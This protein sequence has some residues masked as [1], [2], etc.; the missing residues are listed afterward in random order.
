MALVRAPLRSIRCAGYSISA[1]FNYRIRT[2]LD[3][4]IYQMGDVSAR[5]YVPVYLLIKLPLIILAGVVFALMFTVR[6]G[7]DASRLA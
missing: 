5:W 3:G 4:H 6:P 1:E 7:R 2:L